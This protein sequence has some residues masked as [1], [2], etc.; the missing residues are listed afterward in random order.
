MNNEEKFICLMSGGTD[1]P[2]ACYLMIENGYTP[3]IVHFHLAPSDP[4]SDEILKNGVFKLLKILSNYTDSQIKSYLIPH[5]KIIEELTKSNPGK[6]ICILCR[7]MMYRI[8]KAIALKEGAKAIVTGESLGE[9]ASQTPKN[10]RVMKQA[11]NDFLLIQPL[12]ALNKLEIEAIAKRIG[13]YEA[14]IQKSYTCE[15]TPR[16]PV[17]H[18]DLNKIIEV[19]NKINIRTIVAQSLKISKV[20]RI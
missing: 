2:V 7:R 1:S 5:K 6:M 11:I 3:I 10:L 12:I 18:A 13:T 9:K 16:Y 19:E 17:T 15:A 4:V 14:S 20:I 8:A